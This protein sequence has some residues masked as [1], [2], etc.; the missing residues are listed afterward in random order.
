LFLL[1]S[2]TKD[3][4]KSHHL[5]VFCFSPSSFM[6]KIGNDDNDLWSSSSSPC[7]LAFTPLRHENDDLCCHFCIFFSFGLHYSYEKQKTMM[8][9]DR[10]HL[11]LF[12][13]SFLLN[14][15]IMTFVIVLMSFIC[16]LCCSYERKKTMMINHHHRCLL[17]LFSFLSNMKTTAQSCHLH[18]F[19]STFITPMKNR[20]W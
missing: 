3:N 10:C 16:C 7:P 13:F 1:L 2:N 6:W 18:F 15:K 5:H 19:V 17:L 12:L 8:I 4:G 20:K 9:Y 11:F 14:T